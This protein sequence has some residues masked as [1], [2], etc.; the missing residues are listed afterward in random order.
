MGNNSGEPQS[1]LRAD[2]SLWSAAEQSN[3]ELSVAS[4]PSDSDP[5][6]DEQV[7][8]LVDHG[9]EIAAARDEEIAQLQVEH[10]WADGVAQMVMDPTLTPALRQHGT[11]LLLDFFT[12][13]DFDQAIRDLH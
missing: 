9:D 6:H 13:H 12:D 7:I 8:Q 3:S 5:A 4:E 2:L 1:P 11:P 10:D